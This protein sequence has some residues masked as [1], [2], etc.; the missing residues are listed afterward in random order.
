MPQPIHKKELRVIV[1]ETRSGKVIKEKYGSSLLWR[2]E[3]HNKHNF[4]ILDVN[5]MICKSCGHLISLEAP[6][7]VFVN[8]GR[9]EIQRLV[10]ELCSNESEYKFKEDALVEVPIIHETKG[11]SAKPNRK[12]CK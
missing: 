7:R 11:G 1:S 4:F 5:K 3:F 9:L 6:R 10:C 2:K 8:F 12:Q